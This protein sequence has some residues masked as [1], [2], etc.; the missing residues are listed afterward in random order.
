MGSNSS[1]KVAC[2]HCTSALLEGIVDSGYKVSSFPYLAAYSA[3]LPADDD[4]SS[5]RLGEML[6]SRS[7]PASGWELG[8]QFADS[9]GCQP[10][11]F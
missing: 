8:V 4:R 1:D 7:R 3:A 9:S 5:C 10:G 6:P 2:S 11:R